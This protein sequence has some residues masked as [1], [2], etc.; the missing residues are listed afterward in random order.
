M[1]VSVFRKG[2]AH[3]ERKFQTKGAS[4]TRMIALSCVIEISAVHCF[5]LS[6]SMRVTD[7]CTDSQN[8]DFQ[9]H[10]SIAALCGK[11]CRSA[12][13]HQTSEY[14]TLVYVRMLRS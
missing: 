6:Q 12:A 9:D 1:E 4:Q 14:A 2:V 5:V 3:F 8:Y 13:P 11:N 10:A 7:R